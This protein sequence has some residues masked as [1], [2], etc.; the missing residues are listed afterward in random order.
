[1]QGY[2]GATTASAGRTTLASDV[3]EVAEAARAAGRRLV[4]L[5]PVAE[6]QFP[7]LPGVAFRQIVGVTVP[8]Q[9]L[10]ISTRPDEVFPYR[11]ELFLAVL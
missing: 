10:S 5:S 8:T 4:L 6:P 7:A 9:A 3:D 2:C 11:I 1:V